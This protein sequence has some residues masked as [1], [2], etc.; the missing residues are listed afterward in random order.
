MDFAPMTVTLVAAEER[1][2]VFV[3]GQY[4]HTHYYTGVRSMSMKPLLRKQCA[5]W[6]FTVAAAVPS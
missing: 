2:L 1:V 5:T 6:C 4:T 3:L